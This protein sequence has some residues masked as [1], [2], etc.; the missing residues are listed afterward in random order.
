MMSFACATSLALLISSSSDIPSYNV[1]ILEVA[2]GCSFAL[3]TIRL[4]FDILMSRTKQSQEDP[5]K[6]S[7]IYTAVPNKVSAELEEDI[8]DILSHVMDRIE[9]SLS[10]DKDYA[11]LFRY[12]YITIVLLLTCSG[13]ILTTSYFL[14]FAQIITWLTAL[15]Y[16]TDVYWTS[17]EITAITSL[18]KEATREAA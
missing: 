5:A 12:L 15:T 8:D 13:I 10:R 18:S 1:Y 4:I 16:M 7:P 9:T 11:V 3:G 17:A 2:I 6:V 14:S